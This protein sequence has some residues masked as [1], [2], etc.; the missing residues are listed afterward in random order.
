MK[1]RVLVCDISPSLGKLMARRF[2]NTGI[3]ADFCRGSISSISK[4]MAAKKYS[5]LLFFAFSP[6]KQI[7]E[8]VKSTAESGII[9]FVGLYTSSAAV[10]RSFRNAG[11]AAT[12]IM[13]CSV[14]NMCTK[15]M[16]R[17]GNTDNIISQT[18]IFL[19]ETGFPRQ[20]KGFAYLARLSTACLQAPERLWGGM[21]E[22]YGETA[23][24]LSTAPSLVERAVRNLSTHAAEN[25]SVYRLTDGRLSQ[26]PTNTELI[27]AVC[28]KISRR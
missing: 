26:K 20:L 13:P 14:R 5:C 9:V 18:E 8:L 1:E 25:G 3:P 11:A 24:K 19:E 28:D 7:L 6:D 22:L 4:A 17:M 23:E 21:S 12:F 27:C 2:A 15:I 10:H 16:I